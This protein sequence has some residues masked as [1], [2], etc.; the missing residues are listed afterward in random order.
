MDAAGLRRDVSK[1]HSMVHQFATKADIEKLFS[2][3]TRI[4]TLIGDIKD[5]H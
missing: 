4:R 5:D 2:E 1:L 3:T